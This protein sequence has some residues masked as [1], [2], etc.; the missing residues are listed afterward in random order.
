ML[1]G[2]QYASGRGTNGG[3]RVMLRKPHSLAG[4]AIQVGCANFFLAVTAKFTISQV[5][6]Q[7]KDNVGLLTGAGECGSQVDAQRE[8]NEMFGKEPPRFSIRS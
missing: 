8:K 4:Q 1:T 2:Q 7:N 3:P 5:I 6:S